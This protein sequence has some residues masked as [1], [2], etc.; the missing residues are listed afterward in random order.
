MPD[1]LAS[2]P[3]IAIIIVHYGDPSATLRCLRS[4]GG[5]PH[6]AAVIVV[7]NGTQE[8]GALIAQAMDGLFAEVATLRPDEAMPPHADAALIQGGG[9]RGFAAGCNAGLRAVSGNGGI[10]HTWLL[11]NDAALGPGSLSALAACAASHPRAIIGA[12]VVHADAPDRLQAAGGVRYLPASS[13]IRPAHEGASLGDVPYLADPRLDYIYGASM[14]IPMQAVRAVG[15]L[16]EGFFLFYEEVDYCTR[17]QAAGFRLQWCRDCVIRHEQGAST[18]REGKASA[19]RLALTAYHEARSTVR[20]TRRHHP[21]LLPSV[22]AARL[23]AKP[24]FLAFRRQWRSIP[25]AL[26]G[27]LAGL[28]A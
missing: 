19:E 25:A 23:F 12:T 9:N 4:I 10:T 17:A 28:A 5:G 11:N 26:R 2:S 3:R 20:F 22:L 13:R 27:V 14:L 16:D 21:A 8:Q 18:G 7:N 6:G 1:A 24:L 15:M